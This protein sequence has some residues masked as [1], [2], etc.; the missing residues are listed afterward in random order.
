MTG[1]LRRRSVS[2]TERLLWTVVLVALVADAALTIYGL[3]I[4]LREL[5]PVARRAFDVGGV[6]GFIGLKTLA[7]C[8]AVLGRLVIPDGYGAM[9]PAL[10]AVPWIVAATLNAVTLLLAT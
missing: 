10:L 8:L 9:V 2:Q 7:V 3:G 4:G 5:N 6:V 1:L